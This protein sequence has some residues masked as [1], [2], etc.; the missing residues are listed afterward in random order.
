MLFFWCVLIKSK[1][2]NITWHL[3][4]FSFKKFRVLGIWQKT[5]KAAQM[6]LG[7]KVDLDCTR[8]FTVSYWASLNPVL[9]YHLS[10]TWL[11]L[12][13][14]GADTET[15]TKKKLLSSPLHSAS[16]HNWNSVYWALIRRVRSCQGSWSSSKWVFFFFLNLKLGD[17][18]S[19]S[20]TFSIYPRPVTE[21]ARSVPLGGSGPRGSDPFLP[22]LQLS[23]THPGLLSPH[24]PQISAHIEG[25]RKL[26]HRKNGGKSHGRHCF[27][28]G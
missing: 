4:P 11:P 24:H 15:F 23:T 16:Q 7:S 17:K 20:R 26:G 5:K 27:A 9:K 12:A 1:K 21:P 3:C 6:P 14:E 25:L 10:G 18:R 13:V 28:L 8:L 19:W 2:T 22:H